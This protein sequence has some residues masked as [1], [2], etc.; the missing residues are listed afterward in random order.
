LTEPSSDEIANSYNRLSYVAGASGI[1]GAEPNSDGLGRGHIPALDGL[2]GIA[3]VWVILFHCLFVLPRTSPAL[4]ETFIGRISYA[5]YLGVDLFFVLSGFLITGIL[6]DSRTYHRA[7]NFYARRVLR[8]F[9]LYFALLAGGLIASHIFKMWPSPQWPDWFFLANLNG[10]FGIP[11]SSLPYQHLWSLAVEEQYYI[12][13]PWMIFSTS[14]TWA[15]RISVALLIASVVSRFVLVSAHL[16]SLIYAITPFHLDGLAVGHG[17]LW[18]QEA[19]E[20]SFIGRGG[21]R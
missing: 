18:L 17:S 14:R 12:V 10:H 16:E 2:R 1:G 9:P 21:Q 11:Q 5:G 13:W 7:R 19:S 6:F 3:I 15:M 4:S 8:I 20:N